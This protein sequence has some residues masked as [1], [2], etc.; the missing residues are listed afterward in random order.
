MRKLVLILVASIAV[1][2]FIRAI[3]LSN[4]FSIDHSNEYSNDSY[5]DSYLDGSNADEL[6]TGEIVSFVVE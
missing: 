5:N 6:H 2:T 4:D 3:D 1:L